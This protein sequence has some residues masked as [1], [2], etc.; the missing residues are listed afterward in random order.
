MIGYAYTKNDDVRVTVSLLIMTVILIGIN[1][2]SKFNAFSDQH[3]CVNQI[4]WHS[5]SNFPW[6][7]AKRVNLTQLH[8]RRQVWALETQL[9]VDCGLNKSSQLTVTKPTK[10]ALNGIMQDRTELPKAIL[11]NVLIYR[12]SD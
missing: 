1:C 2:A 8:S 7:N 5:R 3:E 9:T 6:E 4:E 12:F 11:N 10:S